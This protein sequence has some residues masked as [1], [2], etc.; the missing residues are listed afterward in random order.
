LD[1]TG[2]VL[3]EGRSDAMI[4]REYLVVQPFGTDIQE[5]RI[6]GLDFVTVHRVE[7]RA[8]TEM[9]AGD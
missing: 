4:R 8:T 5:V 2:K 6:A 7:C 1:S 3:G 9:V